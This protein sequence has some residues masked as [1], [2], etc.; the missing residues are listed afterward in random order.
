VGKGHKLEREQRR[1]YG[2]FG[3]EENGVKLC[4]YSITS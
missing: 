1:V 2:G 3:E 4:V